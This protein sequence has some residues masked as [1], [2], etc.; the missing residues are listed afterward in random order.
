MTQGL[1]ALDLGTVTGWALSSEGAVTSGTW[2]FRPGRYEGGGMRY[3]RFR[4]VIEEALELGRVGSVYF[5]EVRGHRGTDAAHVYGGLL[6]TLSALCEERAIPYA[7]VPVG[8]IKRHATGAG[9]AGKAAMVAA[10]MARG[11]R[12]ADDNEAD[13][14]WLLDYV[15]TVTRSPDLFATEKEAN[16]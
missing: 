2:A 1:L 14:L 10:A 6:G 7:G 3:L 11:W 8:T 4:R 5:E 12:P 16:R 9:N 13:A 15:I